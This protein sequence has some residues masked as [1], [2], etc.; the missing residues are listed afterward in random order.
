MSREVKQKVD[1]PKTIHTV[2]GEQ[3]PW[4]QLEEAYLS[5]KLFAAEERCRRCSGV[6]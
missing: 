5:R 3:L 2:N 1:P 6:V 4:I